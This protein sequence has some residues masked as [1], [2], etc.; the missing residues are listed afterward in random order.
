VIWSLSQGAYFLVGGRGAAMALLLAG[1]VGLFALQRDGV[2]R[3]PLAA[4][5]LL[6]LGAGTLLTAWLYAKTSPAWANRYLAVIVGPLIVLFGLGLSRSGRLGLIA[7]ALVCS[8]WVLD[9]VAT[10]LDW[11]SN[12]GT[13]IAKV[14]AEVGSGAL[15]LSTQPEQV[16]T[17]AYYLPGADHYGTPLGRVADPRVMD[18]RNA[19]ERLR[20]SSVRGVLLPMLRTLKPGQRVVLVTPLRNQTAPVWLKIISKDSA[21]WYWALMRDSQLQ[22]VDTESADWARAG[23]AV[24]VSVFVKP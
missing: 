11:K 22:L 21:K 19:L 10:S 15:V 23:V 18:W 12:V 9:P 2:R 8:F 17:I 7:L 14:R 1:G 6:I 4:R 24:N 3:T 5:C 20:R 16:P 13:A